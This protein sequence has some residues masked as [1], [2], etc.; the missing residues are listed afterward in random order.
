DMLRTATNV[1]GDCMVTCLVA[2]SEG[3]LDESIYYDKQA[4]VTR[5]AAVPARADV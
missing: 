2:K 3:A 1:M 5:S 4:G